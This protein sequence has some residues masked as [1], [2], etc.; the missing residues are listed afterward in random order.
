MNKNDPMLLNTHAL[1]L[2]ACDIYVTPPEINMQITSMLKD[3]S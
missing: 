1:L 2:L 3:D